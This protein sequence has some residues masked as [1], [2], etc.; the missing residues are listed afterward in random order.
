MAS[1]VVHF[2]VVGK[3]GEALRTFYGDLFEWEFHVP[4][5]MDYGLVAPGQNGIGGG[6]GT[7]PDGSSVATFYV[8]VPDLR[9]ALERAQAL[10]GRTIMEPLELPTVSFALLADPEGNVVG[11]VKG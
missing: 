2:E 5:G 3:D 9:E 1:P 11:I 8:Q 6:I 7:S 4:Q 10:G